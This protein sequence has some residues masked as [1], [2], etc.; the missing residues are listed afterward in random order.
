MYSGNNQARGDIDKDG[1][2]TLGFEAVAN[3]LPKGDYKVYIDNAN[4]HENGEMIDGILLNQTV[5]PLIAK[6][7][8]THETSGLTVKVDSSQRTFDIKV[9]RAAPVPRL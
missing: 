9:E 8:V 5:I 7:Y 1:K 3:G 2:Y 6:K 4:R